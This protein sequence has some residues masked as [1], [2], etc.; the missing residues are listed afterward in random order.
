MRMITAPCRCPRRSGGSS[1]E[2]ELLAWKDSKGVPIS[3]I[4]IIYITRA[5][6]RTWEECHSPSSFF[7][8]RITSLS[9]P[10][11]EQMCPM[12]IRHL[13]RI[14]VSSSPLLRKGLAGS[15]LCSAIAYLVGDDVCGIEWEMWRWMQMREAQALASM[16]PAGY[17]QSLRERGVCSLFGV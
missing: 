3:R 10:L 12:Y 15:V 4:L 9:L 2:Q 6:T 8:S 14:R 17:N 11:A 7:V 1:D 13:Q 16:L 5:R